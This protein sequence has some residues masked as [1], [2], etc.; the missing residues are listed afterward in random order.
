MVVHDTSSG[1]VLARYPLAGPVQEFVD[2]GLR[3]TASGD[4]IALV[5]GR[6]RRLTLFDRAGR[7]EWKATLP[8]V[9]PYAGISVIGDTIYLA[10]GGA[11]GYKCGGR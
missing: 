6:A 2:A 1:K 9:M 5:E 11:F 10:G 4:G 3:R 7:A 8:R